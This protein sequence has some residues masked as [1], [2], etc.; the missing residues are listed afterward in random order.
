MLVHPDLTRALAHD[1]QHELLR[2]AHDPIRWPDS[3]RWRRRKKLQ[4]RP[5][6][7]VLAA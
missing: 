5:E 3:L 1:R 6:D 2:A 4:R 7:H